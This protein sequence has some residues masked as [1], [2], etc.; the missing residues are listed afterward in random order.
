MD[1]LAN[2]TAHLQVASTHAC[3]QQSQG[4][5]SETVD[6]PQ[7][8][9][10]SA[11]Q[12]LLCDAAVKSFLVDG[13]LALPLKELGSDFHKSMYEKSKAR[14]AELQEARLDPRYVFNDLPE[15]STVIASPTLRGAL[16]SLLGPDYCQHPHRSM[17]TKPLHSEEVGSDQGAYP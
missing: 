7:A 3:A 6:Q 15:M 11:E 13:F 17:H 12:T 1:C 4:S 8:F 16:T 9:N 5:A 10:A 2:L 14:F